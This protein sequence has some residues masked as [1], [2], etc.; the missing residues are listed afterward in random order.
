LKAL[1]SLGL[2]CGL[3]VIVTALVLA[4][5]AIANSD[6]GSSV[7]PDTSTAFKS[8]LDPLVTPSGANIS[9]RLYRLDDRI[10]IDIAL[11]TG[12]CE[13]SGSPTYAPSITTVSKIPN[14]YRPK[15]SAGNYVRSTESWFR[16][17]SNSTMG[18]GFAYVDTNGAIVFHVSTSDASKSWWNSCTI[19]SFTMQYSRKSP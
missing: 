7:T 18:D 17:E 3:I 9:T 6:S 4:I 13:P 14:S 10:W 1:K 11:W 2:V 16:S 8:A 5:V 12:I 15:N 19:N